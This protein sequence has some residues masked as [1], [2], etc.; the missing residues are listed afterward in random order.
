M[1]IMIKTTL[2]IEG[3]KCKMCEAHVNDMIKQSFDVKK[4]RSSAKDGE[5][6]V[7]SEKALDAE[8][9][10]SQIEELGFKLVSVSSEG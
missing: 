8:K 4:V 6:V 7:V 10:G 1:I 3:M 9:L 5:T 2:K